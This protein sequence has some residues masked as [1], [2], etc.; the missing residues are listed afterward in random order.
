M[1]QNLFVGIIEEVGI[2]VDECLGVWVG[3]TEGCLLFYQIV[4]ARM[5]MVRALGLCGLSYWPATIVYCFWGVRW[6]G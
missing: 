2:A 4:C 1:L 3:T 6:V 5:R